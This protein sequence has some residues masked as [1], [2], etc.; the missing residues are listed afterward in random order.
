MRN[1]VFDFGGVL[2]K[3]DRACLSDLRQLLSDEDITHVLGF[4]N[5]KD[6]T[7]RARFETGACDTRYFLERT[8]ALCKSG[9]TEQ[10]VTDKRSLW[11]TW[12]PT[13][14]LHKRTSVGRLMRV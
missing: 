13:A 7:L 1:I 8:L 10:Q 9:T 14:L 3:H 5:D 2:M 11:M 12:Q 6:D 4:G